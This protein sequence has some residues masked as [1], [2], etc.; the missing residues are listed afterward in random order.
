MPIRAAISAM[1]AE[2]ALIVFFMGPAAAA[3]E[4][5][6]PLDKMRIP[7]A[8][9]EVYHR[10]LVVELVLAVPSA[11]SQ[12][13]LRERRHLIKAE[14]EKALGDK[15]IAELADGNLALT[16]KRV[17]RSAAQRAA[18]DVAITDALIKSV[19]LQ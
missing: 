6:F 5:Y 11:D 1:L 16:V 9:D 4:V 12:A 13:R 18:G 7:F 8:G 10:V 14:I 15:P 19:R 3:G 2:V 17:A